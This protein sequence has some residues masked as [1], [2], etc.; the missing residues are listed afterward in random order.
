M[1]FN[2]IILILKFY[3]YTI[4]DRILYLNQTSGVI[5]KMIEIFI[6]DFFL[7]L[8]EQYQMLSL[9]WTPPPPR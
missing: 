2:M 5:I 7:Q 1:I 8:I 6:L 3:L 4:K 9:G